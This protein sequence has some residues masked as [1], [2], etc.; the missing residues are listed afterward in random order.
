LQLL[1]EDYRLYREAGGRG[2]LITLPDGGGCALVLYG[3]TLDGTALV[4][5]QP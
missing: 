2:R 1:A 4:E 3:V 5:A